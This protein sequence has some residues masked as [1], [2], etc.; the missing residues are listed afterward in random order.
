MAQDDSLEIIVQRNQDPVP[1]SDRMK[2]LDDPGFGNLF[3][4]HMAVIRYRE[5]LGWHNATVEARA[6]IAMD[7]ASSVLHYAQEIFE[8]MKA[9]RLADGAT[10]LFRPEENARR[11][12]ASARRMAM[13]ELPEDIFLKSVET[14]VDIDR[15]WFPSA[16]GGSLYLRPFMF[17]SEVFLGVRPAK[18]YLYMVIA[19]PAGA[20]FKQGVSAISIWVSEDYSRAAPGGTGAAKCGG[21]YAASL[22]AQAEAIAQDCDQ[23]VFLDAAEQRWVEEL[24][25]MNLFFVMDDGRLIT[26]PLNGTILPGITRESIMILAREEGLVVS[27]E[28]YAIDQWR[29]DAASGKL[30]ETFA[31]GTAAVVTAVGTVRSQQGA[32]TIGTGGPGQLT[33]KLRMRLVDIQ[34]GLV[35]DQHGWVKRLF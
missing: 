15:D 24:G 13:P 33:E 14:L 16:E 21:N 26:P 19:S 34:R 22:V 7:P 9:Y 2:L 25:G 29:A 35:E 27:E 5:D 32:F 18:E 31:C 6:P 1:A 8:G 4:D 28:A 10:A 11:F 20:Y 30:R 23:V 3:T 12:Q 17:A